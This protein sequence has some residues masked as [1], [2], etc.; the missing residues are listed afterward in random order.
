MVI[1]TAENIQALLS[2]KKCIEL[3]EGAMVEASSGS[4]RLPLRW[5]M[6]LPDGGLMGMMPGY[7]NSPEC[8]GLKVVNIMPKNHGTP[9][10]SHV[11]TMILFEASSGVPLAII[12]AARLT[13]FRT[14][15]ASALATNILA[16]ENSSVLT[17]IGTGEQAH[18]HLSALALV[19]DFQEIRV[20]SQS[21]ERAQAFASSYADDGLSIKPYDNVSASIDGADVVCTMTNAS[22]PFLFS[23]ML[24]EGMHINLVGAS[25]P[26]RQEADASVVFKSRYFIDYEPSA[27]AQAGELIDAYQSG[28]EGTKKWPDEI[29]KVLSG[30]VV[31]RIKDDDVTVYR[32][33]GVVMQDLAVAWYLNEQ[34]RAKGVGSVV[35]F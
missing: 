34:A 11:G 19:R 29:G 6:P 8:F 15:A 31:G 30:H 2:M 33:L 27:K 16:R 23:E 26:N 4:A 21:L 12:D 9:V 28:Q 32:S 1:L 3:M 5:G 17:L 14:A 20:C 22:S 7:S 24:Q 10:S 35:K 13:A 18:A 25:T